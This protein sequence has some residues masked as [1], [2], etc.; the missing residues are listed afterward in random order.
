MNLSDCVALLDDEKS[1]ETWMKLQEAQKHPGLGR[2]SDKEIIAQCLA[3]NPV[4]DETGFFN[5]RY[6]EILE[7]QG[8]F[9]RDRH[10][11]YFI[12]EIFHSKHWNSCLKGGFRPGP[13][14]KY[15]TRE[16]RQTRL[17]K[18]AHFLAGLKEKPSP[19]TLMELAASKLRDDYDYERA[20][21]LKECMGQYIDSYK[22]LR[23]GIVELNGF[24][25]V[26]QAVE[27]MHFIQQNSTFKFVVAGENLA[28]AWAGAGE[29]RLPISLYTFVPLTD[30]AMWTTLM[31]QELDFLTMGRY[32]QN[33][34]LID[35]DGKKL[36]SLKLNQV[37]PPP[38]FYSSQ[39]YF[40]EA[41]NESL[42]I[43]YSWTL[44][45]VLE[46]ANYFFYNH[47][48]HVELLRVVALVDD[49]PSCEDVACWQNERGKTKNFG[50]RF[51]RG[52]FSRNSTNPNLFVPR[53]KELEPRRYSKNGEG[54]LF[55][56]DPMH[57]GFL[58]G[59]LPMVDFTT[60]QLG[61]CL[62]NPYT[63]AFRTVETFLSEQEKFVVLHTFPGD[64]LKMIIVYLGQDESDG[65]WFIH[66]SECE[67]SLRLGETCDG[68]TPCECIVNRLEEMCS[69]KKDW[70]NRDHFLENVGK[71]IEKWSCHLGKLGFNYV[72]GSSVA[73]D[74]YRL[75]HVDRKIAG[76]AFVVNR[77]SNYGLKGLLMLEKAYKR[78]K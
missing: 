61:D 72:G 4:L 63:L 1:C 57:R 12:R 60:P 36:P 50:Q 7:R 62:S 26:K 69:G 40:G 21:N 30:Q 75:K 71:P 16:V 20:Y 74:Y 31:S 54:M 28:W 15:Q 47:G 76:L 59:R 33:A 73:E 13:F 10:S 14:D 23:V 56:L 19:P 42:D 77:A 18:C 64:E 48:G 53:V 58:Q 9:L 38:S 68:P 78:K 41:A 17:Q 5:T 55:G 32:D 66:G 65:P 3:V 39:Y 22:R 49:R 70:F 51:M 8:Q 25:V 52:V 6:D 37:E 44:T 46:G 27:I 34:H 11:H 29:M 24:P 67:S 45:T 43:A 35:Q 2:M